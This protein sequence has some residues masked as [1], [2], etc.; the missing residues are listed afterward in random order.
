[1][2]FKHSVNDSYVVKA[3]DGSENENQIIPSQEI[4]VGQPLKDS[5]VVD[6]K[7]DIVRDDEDRY[8]N[9]KR[10][11]LENG[12]VL[13]TEYWKD[14]S[15]PEYKSGTT[16]KLP[17]KVVDCPLF[18]PKLLPTPSSDD[19]YDADK[20]ARAS[21]RRR[22]SSDSDGNHSNY[23]D[24]LDWPL[25]VVDLEDEEAHGNDDNLRR[26]VGKIE[27]PSLNG[28]QRVPRLH[29][30]GKLNIPEIFLCGI[31]KMAT[32]HCSSSPLLPTS[33]NPRKVKQP[34]IGVWS[35]TS[36]KRNGLDENTEPVD[37]MVLFVKPDDEII[38]HES[39]FE[40]I[41]AI[42]N[43]AEL[44]EDGNLDPKFNIFC[45]PGVMQ[46][47][48]DATSIGKWRLLPG[49]WKGTWPP[50]K[51]NITDRL[52]KVGKLV[53]PDCFQGKNWKPRPGRVWPKFRLC[54]SNRE[55]GPKKFCTKHDIGRPLD[56]IWIPG[57]NE[58]DENDWESMEVTIHPVRTEDIDDKSKQHGV[59]AINND[60]K[61]DLDG[62]YDPK[63][64]WY[65]PPNAEADLNKCTPI[66]I[67]KSIPGKLGHKWPPV[68][69]KYQTK[70]LSR[71]VG[72][73]PVWQINNWVVP[74]DRQK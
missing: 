45:P 42:R 27:L 4:V 63:D 51:S 31:P 46:C 6:V 14:K 1:M 5:I 48:R 33:Y 74:D 9:K 61:I 39:E 13:L 21:K 10:I 2:T 36:A 72:R 34:M 29:A 20:I 37:V 47:P 50:S 70:R 73:L 71:E 60:A 35:P 24:D 55:D 17:E 28:K 68:K 57:P 44:D 7:V 30:V 67:W 40:G 49:K 18:N 23:S 64:I 53:I 32:V 15:A 22:N 43:N 65:L 66:G 41:V 59:V 16:S 3:I 19:G 52:K 26:Q 12:V 54:N 11:I 62:R 58:N 25:V 8:Q 69:P 56:G 38:L